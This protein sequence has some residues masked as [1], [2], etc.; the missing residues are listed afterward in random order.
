MEKT[1]TKKPVVIHNLVKIKTLLFLS[2]RKQTDKR[3]AYARQIAIATGGNAD[4]LYVL[5]QRWR[6]WGLVDCIP[7]TP[8]AYMIADEGLR[9]LSKIDKWFFSGYYSKKRKRRVPGYRGKVEAL[10]REILEA[11]RAIFWWRYMGHGRNDGEE[12][13]NRGFVYYI[14]APFQESSDFSKIENSEGRP[15]IWPKTRLLVV[16]F[17]SA[18][19]A[20]QALPEWGFK[21]RTKELGQAIVDAKIGMVWAKDA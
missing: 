1:K 9:Y 17:G 16:R 10:K 2:M 7:S 6:R 13:S 14:E 5:L 3:A 8:Y 12:D 20:Y 19:A 4:S 21:Q 18:L 11:S 15:V